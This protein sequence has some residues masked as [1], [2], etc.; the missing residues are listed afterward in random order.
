M[1]HMIGGISHGMADISHG[2]VDISHG[3]ADM[4]HG[5]GRMSH[6][7]CLVRN[8]KLL[9]NNICSMTMECLKYSMGGNT[10]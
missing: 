1:S 2:M 9:Y 6:G 5:M 8:R 4:S 10:Y 7:I 3:M